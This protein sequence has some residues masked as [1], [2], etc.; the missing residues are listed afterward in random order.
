MD[1]EIFL[2]NG[3]VPLVLCMKDAMVIVHD[4]TFSTKFKLQI[5]SI[6]LEK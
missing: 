4:L 2:E 5:N 1:V 6:L 3:L